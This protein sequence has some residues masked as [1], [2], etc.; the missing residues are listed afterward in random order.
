MALPVELPCCVQSASLEYFRT[1]RSFIKSADREHLVRQALVNPC[2]DAWFNVYSNMGNAGALNAF[3]VR[4]GADVAMEAAAAAARQDT[5]RVA[6]LLLQAQAAGAAMSADAAS[7]GEE[8]TVMATR[9]G[10]GTVGGA[11]VVH[12]AGATALKAAFKKPC[13]H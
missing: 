13:K 1:A 3:P 8:G 10:G 9:A 11:A 7:A 4:T 6:E 12:A 5:E 2:G